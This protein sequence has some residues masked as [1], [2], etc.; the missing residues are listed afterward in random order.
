MMDRNLGVMD[1]NRAA[2]QEIKLQ[3]RPIPLKVVSTEVSLQKRNITARLMAQVK[4]HLGSIYPVLVIVQKQK[5]H[6]TTMKMWIRELA[7]M[8]KTLIKILLW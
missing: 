3:K 8:G 6:I 5:Q 7:C 2:F 1:K 4:P